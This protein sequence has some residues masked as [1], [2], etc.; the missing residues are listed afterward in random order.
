MQDSAQ[1]LLNMCMSA[2]TPSDFFGESVS[3]LRQ[4]GCGG[5]H[6]AQ[7]RPV[8][9]MRRLRMLARR[10]G[11]ASKR[12]IGVAAVVF[13]LVAGVIGACSAIGMR[14]GVEVAR[15]DEVAEQNPA[16]SDANDGD[17][18]RDQTP[19][20]SSSR[21]EDTETHD[22]PQ[23][24]LVHV[25]GAVANPGVYV[26]D[27]PDVRINDVVLRAGGLTDEADT[28]SV[29]LAAPI[30]DGQKVYIPAAGETTPDAQPQGA[31]SSASFS[32]APTG[33]AQES[34]LININVASAEELTSLS[35]V[36]EATAAAIVKEREANGPFSTP[37]DLM[38]VSG[39]GEKKFA[40]MKDH[41]CV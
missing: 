39:I 14:Q 36:G 1:I 11:L 5:G 10:F 3:A 7:E 6:M 30:T 24:M 32:S 29:N 33:M 17:K 20:G 40:K 19:S 18:A 41:I 27:T 16:G 26:F 31:S 22:A 25:D 4:D 38:R 12:E 37:E 13:V 34:G 9:P 15:T 28:A 21:N 2:A 35:G 8:S 23:R